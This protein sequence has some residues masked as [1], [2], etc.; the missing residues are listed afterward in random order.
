[1]ISAT[2]T[3]GKHDLH[4]F[5]YQGKK[6]FVLTIPLQKERC[7]VRDPEISPTLLRDFVSHRLFIREQTSCRSYSD[8]ELRQLSGHLNVHTLH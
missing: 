3:F 5:G 4:P 6:L 1:M 7:T 8:L 2:D